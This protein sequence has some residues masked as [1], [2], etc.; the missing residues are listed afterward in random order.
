MRLR[1]EQFE[2]KYYV[3]ESIIDDILNQER[4]HIPYSKVVFE[5]EKAIFNLKKNLNND[6][7]SQRL[8]NNVETPDEKR[9][10][11][12][13]RLILK[14]LF[15]LARND[16][17][18]R[19]W[20]SQ[21][22][23]ILSTRLLEIYD[24]SY[25]FQYQTIRIETNGIGYLYV[26]DFGKDMLEEKIVDAKEIVIERNEITIYFELPLVK[27]TFNYKYESKKGFSRLDLLKLIYKGYRKIYD[28]HELEI[29][30][31][32]A[33]IG[34]LL[35]NELVIDKISYE[36]NLSEVIVEIRYFN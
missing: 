18:F 30:G 4:L 27:P 22:I 17:I 16:E 2:R 21:E 11:Q 32:S 3:S 24:K 26:R 29:D 12:E 5:L 34:G 35:F 13:Y 20:F 33:G 28:E 8:Q 9:K 6:S 10:L 23:D 1:Y 25:D 19:K 15:K 36:Q 14:E 7:I 31:E